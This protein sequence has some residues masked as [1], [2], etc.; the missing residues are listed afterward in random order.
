MVCYGKT[1]KKSLESDGNDIGRSILC[2]WNPVFLQ[3]Y[4]TDEFLKSPEFSD[5]HDGLLTKD[6]LCWQVS[7]MAMSSTGPSMAMGS[8]QTAP[9]GNVP[10]MQRFLDEQSKATMG[11]AMMATEGKAVDPVAPSTEAG[12]GSYVSA[13]GTDPSKRRRIT[14]QMEARNQLDSAL[15]SI[16]RMLENNKVCRNC[17]S[18]E[19]STS[20]C[21][22][23]ED[24][25]NL[26]VK[27]RDGLSERKAS[28]QM[29]VTEP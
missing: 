9:V 6:K 10:L 23:P 26:L 20:N 27:V 11:G 24:W 18:S 28:V 7:S 16:Q 19:H 5:D 29:E 8:D 25:E 3:Q 2:V 4:I 14:Q 13:P 22:L 17:M 15:V 12:K 1:R 21:P